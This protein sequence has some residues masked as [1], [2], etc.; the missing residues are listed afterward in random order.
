MF[1]GRQELDQEQYINRFREAPYG[2]ALEMPLS[3]L[4]P[5]QTPDGQYSLSKGAIQACYDKSSILVVHGN[6]RYFDAL[7][8]VGSEKQA[9]ILTEKV[10]N[11]YLDY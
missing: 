11:P 10:K 6:H 4:T 5:T 3:T 7:S 9:L 2:E 8:T 1:E